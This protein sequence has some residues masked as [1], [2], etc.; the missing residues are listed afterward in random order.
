MAFGRGIH[1]CPGGPLARVDERRAFERILDRM[2]DIRL[3][4]GAPR[5]TRRPPLRLRADLDL[6]G[7]TKVH[8]EFEPVEG[9]LG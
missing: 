1:S 6:R 9:I 3:D 5:P 2:H 4:E 8:L 7:L